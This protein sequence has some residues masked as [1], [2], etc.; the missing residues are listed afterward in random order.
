MH[1][2]FSLIITVRET[3]L[4]TYR[5][6]D[7]STGTFPPSFSEGNPFHHQPTTNSNSYNITT[8]YPHTVTT[9][10]INQQTFSPASV[11][12][13]YDYMNSNNNPMVVGHYSKAAQYD[14]SIYTKPL[15][16]PAVDSLYT[17]PYYSSTSHN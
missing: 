5:S 12:D 1:F 16:P 17:T 4:T 14:E 10:T 2:I 15:G 13:E 9:A 3:P 7:H 6:S 11:E 8:P